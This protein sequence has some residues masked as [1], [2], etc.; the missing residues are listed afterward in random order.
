MAI[1][2]VVMSYPAG[3][4]R[5]RSGNRTLAGAGCRS[6]PCASQHR[7]RADKLYNRLAHHFSV[8]LELGP[9]R[10]LEVV[11]SPLASEVV[12][13]YSRIKRRDFSLERPAP[14]ITSGRARWAVAAWRSGVLPGEAQSPHIDALMSMPS[15]LSL[16]VAKSSCA[17][18]GLLGFI[19]SWVILRVVWVQISTHSIPIPAV[20]GG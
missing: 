11:T 13:V 10:A 2:I 12:V 20:A 1:S 7:L 14:D 4:R 18:S 5:P 16:F 6:R 9:G 17:C 15:A 19:L 8:R 3:S